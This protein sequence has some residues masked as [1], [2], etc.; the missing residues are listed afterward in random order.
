MVYLETLR[1]HF[2]LAIW[3]QWTVRRNSPDMGG[4]ESIWSKL[5]FQ[6]Y[7]RLSQPF[8]STLFSEPGY[9]CRKR[10]STHWCAHPTACRAFVW[11][12]DSSQ[13]FSVASAIASSFA[14]PWLHIQSESVAVFPFFG[15]RWPSVT[16]AK[17]WSPDWKLQDE[18]VLQ[19][20][21]VWV[22]THFIFPHPFFSR[23]ARTRGHARSFLERSA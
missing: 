13:S 8:S 23:V 1:Y 10:S 16:A 9:L 12:V 17:R 2:F 18:A 4:T 6:E 11:A 22:A 15:L 3:P 20:Y 21:V 14:A 19:L 5:G 7:H